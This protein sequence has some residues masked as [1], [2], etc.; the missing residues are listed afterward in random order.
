[1]KKWSLLILLSITLLL[2]SCTQGEEETGDYSGII[3]DGK[4]MGYEYTL[5]KEQSTFFWKIGY[6]GNTSK[7]KENA[8]N[9]NNLENFMIAV[10]DCQSELVELIITL[11]YF[12]IVVLTTLFLYKKNR[13]ILNEMIKSG[14]VI[15]ALTVV[16]AIY[17][18]FAT[19]FD[20]SNS[21]LDAKYYYLILTN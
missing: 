19:S 1:M 2:S 21:L 3:S 9:E 17:N 14:G 8:E 18:A 6:K 11:S 4:S 7:I 12:L 16:F 10:G 15:I 13:K 20:L 5:T